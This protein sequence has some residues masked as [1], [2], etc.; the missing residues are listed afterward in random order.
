VSIVKK[1]R[2]WYALIQ[3]PH[4]F[5]T[6]NARS[7]DFATLLSPR[8]IE[9]PPSKKK[10]TESDAAASQEQSQPMDIMND[11]DVFASIDVDQ[12]AAAAATPAPAAKQAP[13]TATATA[14]APAAASED[15][16]SA[17][18]NMSREEMAQIFDDFPSESAAQSSTS[19]MKK[20]R[21]RQ[22]TVN[23]DGEEED[24]DDV[25]EDTH[26]YKG[27]DWFSIAEQIDKDLAAIPEDKK[28]DGNATAPP[29]YQKDGGKVLMYWFDAHED[30]VHKPGVIHVFGKVFDETKRRWRSCCVFV[31]N[32]DRIIHVAPRPGVDMA[33]V[34]EE[35]E[36]LRQQHNIS[37]MK[38]RVV[39]KNYAFDVDGV[40]HGKSS[41]LEVRYPYRE[42]ML[43]SDTQ[44]K[45]F[46]HL[47][48]AQRSGLETF[49]MN[50]NLMGP[51]WLHI[52]NVQPHSNAVRTLIVF[53]Y[54]ICHTSGRR[55]GG[56]NSYF[57]FVVE[58]LVRV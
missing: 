49:I 16:V 45:T 31:E 58:N 53:F 5:G 25:N 40:P 4:P 18:M 48:G 2:I 36:E 13:A 21:P 26:V 54:L 17:I 11:D 12:M 34:K 43:Q 30:V 44:G 37:V 57:V 20:K 27:D 52:K 56:S 33:A 24:D 8:K 14:P 35:M 47:F 7:T 23:S 32:L 22:T 42:P 29:A 46:L 50:R 55:N 41:F 1:R 51:G 10:K 28:N 3:L 19:H 6:P 9:L 38:S 15:P 39:E